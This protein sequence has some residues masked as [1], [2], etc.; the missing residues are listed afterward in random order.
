MGKLVG[1]FFGFSASPTIIKSMV[2][3]GGC[4]A[5]S[6]GVTASAGSPG[7]SVPVSVRSSGD[8]GGIEAETGREP[9][10]GGNPTFPTLPALL[11]FTPEQAV[12]LFPDEGVV[13]G[14]PT[15]SR[16]M[17]E[18]VIPFGREPKEGLLVKEDAIPMSA[19]A[20]QQLIIGQAVSLPSD[21]DGVPELPTVSRKTSEEVTS[22]DRES[23][24][25]SLG[26]ED[27][28]TISTVASQLFVKGWG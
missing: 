19:V 11:Q 12:S 4:E 1:P 8:K 5:L 15:V 2:V 18:E 9:G 25:G 22:F 10:S 28:L 23:G 14:L 27:A 6:L 17:P 20:R 24:D 7:A 13:P 26:R 16:K 21:A 3:H